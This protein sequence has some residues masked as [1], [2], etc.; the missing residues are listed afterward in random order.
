[1]KFFPTKCYHVYN[2]GNNQKRLFR[3]VDNYLLFLKKMRKHLSHYSHIMAYCL[4]PNHFHW[5]IYI[6]KDTKAKIIPQGSNHPIIK[7]IAIMLRSYTRAF[8]NRYD[9]T[10]SLFRQRT[11]SK[12]IDTLN[13]G[14][15]CLHY[16]H[17]NPI[18][19][20]LVKE[21]GEWPF[22]SFPDYIGK[23]N[24]TLVNKNF[25]FNCLDINPLT[26]QDHAMQALDSKK[27]KHLY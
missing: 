9:K 11:K 7:E 14:H 2:Q 10:G 26:F 24:G 22:S 27:I 20:G 21:M 19:S 1:M 5:L 4:M 3:D 25:A 15:I 18:Q 6:K 16:I 8:N 13:Y 17:Q 12:E 23:R